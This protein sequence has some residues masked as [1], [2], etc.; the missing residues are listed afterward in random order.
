MKVDAIIAGLSVTLAG[1]VVNVPFVRS[2]FTTPARRAAGAGL[3]AA[4]M[5][6]GGV[7]IER[8]VFNAR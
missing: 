1:F 7:L 4:A 2:R 6:V 5:A 8:L 3:L